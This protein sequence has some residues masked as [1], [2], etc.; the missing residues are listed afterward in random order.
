MPDNKKIIQVVVSLVV[1]LVLVNFYFKNRE[2]SMV[3][4]YDMVTVFVA[5]RDIPPHTLMQPALLATRQIPLKFMEPGAVMVKIMDQD[6]RRVLGKVTQISIQSGAQVT[7]NALADPAPNTTGIA[8]ITPAGKRAF[9]L[10]LGNTDVGSIILPGDHIDV[11]ATFTVHDPKTNAQTRGTYTI[12]QN[13][14]VL[15]VGRELRNPN[16]DVTKKKEGAEALMLTLALEP[17]DCER[18]SL[19]QA[20]SQGE[21]N[22][23]VRPHGDANIIPLHG[24]TPNQIIQ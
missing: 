16:E 1:T 13:V 3:S 21:I 8:P 22:V 7:Q 17:A 15:A 23:V 5:A 6:V 14:L 24:A 9:L 10:R 19:A 12:L 20:E 4:T 11:M 18:L 2:Q